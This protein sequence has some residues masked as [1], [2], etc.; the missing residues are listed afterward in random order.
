MQESDRKDKLNSDKIKKLE[1]NLTNVSL[2]AASLY[3]KYTISH[4]RLYLIKYGHSYSKHKLQLKLT[5]DILFLF[6]NVGAISV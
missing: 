2:S 1:Q 4:L 6:Q 5:L 3:E